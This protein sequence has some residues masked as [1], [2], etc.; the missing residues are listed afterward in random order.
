MNSCETRLGEIEWIR[1]DHMFVK[2]CIPLSLICLPFSN[3]V[4]FTVAWIHNFDIKQKVL[5]DKTVMF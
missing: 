4:V 5:N 1:N 2:N 3:E